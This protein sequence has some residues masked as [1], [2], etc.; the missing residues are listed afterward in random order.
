MFCN[1]APKPARPRAILAAIENGDFH[2]GLSGAN[3]RHHRA[4]PSKNT[5]FFAKRIF[6]KNW[7]KKNNTGV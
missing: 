4:H 2:N 5:S 6:L 3:Q 1:A 7:S